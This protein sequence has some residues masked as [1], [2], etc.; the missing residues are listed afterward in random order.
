MA[1]L[2]LWF[3]PAM[4]KKQETP[5]T[6]SIE[7]KEEPI[8]AKAL[9]PDMEQYWFVGENGLQKGPFSFEQLSSA[10]LGKEISLHTLLWTEGLSRWK[11]IEQLPYLA[12]RL[13]DN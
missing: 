1:Y 13:Q 12:A 10:W 11:K 3:L 6:L 4:P 8:A 2:T 5:K 9:E 7:E